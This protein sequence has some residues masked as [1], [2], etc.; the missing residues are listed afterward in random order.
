MEKN[1]PSFSDKIVSRD[2]IHLTENVEVVKTE[3]EMAE[4]L[5]NLFGNVIKRIMIPKYSEYDPSIEDL[6][7]ARLER[8]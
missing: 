7:I 6:K 1:K 4:T 8:F 3:L 5:N 2:R